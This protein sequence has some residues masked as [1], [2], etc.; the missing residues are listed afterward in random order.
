MNGLHVFLKTLEEFYRGFNPL[1][2]KKAMEISKTD[3][4]QLENGTKEAAEVIEASP[5]AF[6]EGGFGWVIVS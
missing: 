5:N 2:Q 1:E 6:P 4:R 3:Q